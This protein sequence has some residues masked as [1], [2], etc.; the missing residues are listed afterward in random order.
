MAREPIRGTAFEDELSFAEWQGLR[1]VHRAVAGKP[2]YEQVKAYM[3][4]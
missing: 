4:Y 3:D 2:F 1:A